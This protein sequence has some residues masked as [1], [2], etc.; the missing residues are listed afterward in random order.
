MLIK[1]EIFDDEKPLARL[2]E[3]YVDFTYVYYML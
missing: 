3:T 2:G 1:K